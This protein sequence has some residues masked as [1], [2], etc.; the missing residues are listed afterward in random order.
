MS[1]LQI[2]RIQ[3]DKFMNFSKRIFVNDPSYV[4]YEY[5]SNLFKDT[6]D[7]PFRNPH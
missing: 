6:L 7:E 4:L 5:I 3:F 2:G 1:V